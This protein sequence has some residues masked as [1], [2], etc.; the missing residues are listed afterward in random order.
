MTNWNNRD[1]GAVGMARA[2][3]QAADGVV[4]GYYPLG[5][6]NPFQML[7]YSRAFE[8]G[9]YPVPLRTTVEIPLLEIARR[10]GRR[11]ALHIHWTSP[12]L[13]GA[14]D[15]A[16]AEARAEEFLAMLDRLAADGVR[17]A[18]T[19]H[20]VLPHDCP[21]PEVESRLRQSLA[22]RA[23]VI[24]TMNPDTLEAVSGRYSLPPE[25]VIQVRHPS[26]RGAYPDFPNRGEARRLM[27]FRPRDLVVAFVGSI[28]PYKGL[29]D[30]AAAL[31]E[32]EEDDPYVAAV[33][34]GS[35]QMEDASVLE[36]LGRVP[37]LDLI[38]RRTS[39]GEV[40]TIMHAADV[41]ALP[42]V[43]SLN[44]G[45]AL[46]AA[47]FGLP[48]VAP[49]IGPFIEMIDGGLGL[50]YDPMGGPGAIAAALRQSRGFVARFDPSVARA[51][52]D[53]AEPSVVSE[54]FM[55]ALLGR[56]DFG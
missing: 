24:H 34:A 44:S 52:T 23:D 47:T 3:E 55:S 25:K 1:G 16:G 19:V 33:V 35:F 20:N 50:G 31:R 15:T 41:V 48:I 37:R 51:Y 38:P 54:A 36:A 49:R 6:L 46:L 40:T 7:L 13:E 17:I 42:Y 53:Q 21:Q 12:V 39:L 32:V 26:Y 30:L 29:F 43:A 4:L 10:M 27:G 28:K 5:R 9:V 8:H 22:D 2:A 56:L 45:A 11:T 14:D 18:W